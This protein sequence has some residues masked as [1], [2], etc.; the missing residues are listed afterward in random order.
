MVTETLMPAP[1]YAAARSQ[2]GTWRV[3]NVAD[4]STTIVDEVPQTGLAED[5]AVD[6]AGILNEMTDQD[7]G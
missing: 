3:I 2:D 6:I 5:Q 4:G 7:D 1:K